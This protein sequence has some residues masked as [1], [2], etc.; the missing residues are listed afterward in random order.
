MKKLL[1]QPKVRL[2]MLLAV[3]AGLLLL[4]L[5]APPA[6]GPQQAQANAVESSLSNTGKSIQGADRLYIGRAEWLTSGDD[7]FVDTPTVQAAE[8]ISVPQDQAPIPHDTPTPEPTV[9]PIP[10]SAMARFQSG[11]N[12]TVYL[13]LGDT[14]I[15]VS[16]GSVLGNGEYK[17]ESISETA[18]SIRYLPMN[19][20]HELSLS[21]LE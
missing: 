6:E 12:S 3:L 5:T 18:V 19:H 2:S 4:N 1:S 9:P 17:I 7:I 8:P 14:A 11:K 13:R 21:G 16:E 20:L 15:P 10:Y